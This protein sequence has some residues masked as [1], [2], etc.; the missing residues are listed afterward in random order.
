MSSNENI[1]LKYDIV[2]ELKAPINEGE[3]LGTIE[4]LLN[5]ELISRKN[6]VVSKKIDAINITWCIANVLELYII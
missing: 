3:L 5:G 1:E 2:K 6:I 4:Y